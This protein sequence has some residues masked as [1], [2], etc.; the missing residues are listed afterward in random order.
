MELERHI[1]WARKEEYN[2]GWSKISTCIGVEVNQEKKCKR[3]SHDQEANNANEDNIEQ[4]QKT[5]VQMGKA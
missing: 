2:N 1:L 3:W 4:V 5:I